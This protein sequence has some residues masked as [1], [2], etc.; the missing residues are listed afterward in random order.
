MTKKY[1]KLKILMIIKELN[2][3]IKWIYPEICDIHDMEDF[4]KIGYMI[5]YSWLKKKLIIYQDGLEVRNC[6]TESG[7][8]IRLTRFNGLIYRLVITKR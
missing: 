8:I 6:A 2:I 1:M 4:I 5:I 7:E 3:V